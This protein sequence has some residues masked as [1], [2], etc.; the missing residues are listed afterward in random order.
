MAKIEDLQSYLK[1]EKWAQIL[2]IPDK[3]PKVQQMTELTASQSRPSNSRD[4]Q[5]HVV[6]VEMLPSN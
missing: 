5:P 3:L 6:S 2:L 4:K 1:A